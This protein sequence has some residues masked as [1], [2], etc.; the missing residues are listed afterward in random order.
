MGHED[1]KIVRKRFGF[2]KV[3]NAVG[4]KGQTGWHPAMENA[5]SSGTGDPEVHEDQDREIFVLLRA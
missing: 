4:T 1:E 2:K 3:A 5:K